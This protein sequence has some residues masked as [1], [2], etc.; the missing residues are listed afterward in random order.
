MIFVSVKTDAD[1]KKTLSTANPS[2]N[3]N[4]EYFFEFIK[5][6]KKPRIAEK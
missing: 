1:T 5:S 6:N 2:N 4:F 3:L